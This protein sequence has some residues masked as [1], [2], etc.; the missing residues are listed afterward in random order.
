MHC[1]AEVE[2]KQVHKNLFGAVAPKRL[3]TYFRSSP[4]NFGENWSVSVKNPS[5]PRPRRVLRMA[6][7]IDMVGLRESQIREKIDAGE[8]P[9]PIRLSTSGRAIGFLEHEIEEYID[10]RIRERD[11]GHTSSAAEQRRIKAAAEGR[12]RAREERK[13]QDPPEA[14]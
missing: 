5:P 7:T 13:R 9:K 10:A 8:F 3:T 1:A 14:A 12:R 11:Q 6:A 4:K 2:R